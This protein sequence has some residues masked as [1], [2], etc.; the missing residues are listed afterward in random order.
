MVESHFQIGLS[1]IPKMT[2]EANRKIHDEVLRIARG[3]NHADTDEFLKEL[4]VE[5]G[6]IR[7]VASP[8][9]RR[10]GIGDE[11]HESILHNRRAMQERLTLLNK[12]TEYVKR[13]WREIDT[14]DYE[15]PG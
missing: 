4:R 15:G 5:I 6:K 1:K 14:Y 3:R 2:V 12:V 10:R 13:H 9:S 11:E 7:I 8:A